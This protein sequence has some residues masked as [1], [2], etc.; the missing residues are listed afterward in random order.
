MTLFLLQLKDNFSLNSLESI[1]TFQF[2]FFFRKSFFFLSFRI[3]VIAF[4]ISKKIGLLNSISPEDIDSWISIK[5]STR[6]ADLEGIPQFRFSF[7]KSTETSSEDFLFRFLRF[8]YI[9]NGQYFKILIIH[10]I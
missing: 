10:S 6:L 9:L 5:M 2:T 8:F 4:I 1:S 7:P 3:D